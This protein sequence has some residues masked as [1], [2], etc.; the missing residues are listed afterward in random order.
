MHCKWIK[1]D[2]TSPHLSI[3]LVSSF[4][5]DTHYAATSTRFDPRWRSKASGKCIANEHSEAQLFDISTLIYYLHFIQTL[6]TLQLHLNQIRNEGV[7][8]LA[9]ALQVNTVSPSYS[10]SHHLSII[11]ILRRHSLRS[12][13]KTTR[14]AMKEHCIWQMH[15]KWTRWCSISP[16][17]HRSPI[18]F[19]SHRHLLRWIFKTTRSAM[20]EHC[21]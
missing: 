20:K 9:N 7:L 11:F 6:T 10:T 2:S 4:H 15:C 13:F 19:I 17:L 16:H 8:H 5:T 21:I 3:H 14:F 12:I 18:I 1:W